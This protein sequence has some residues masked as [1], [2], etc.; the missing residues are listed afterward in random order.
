MP[1]PEGAAELAVHAFHE[2]AADGAPI[3]QRRAPRLLVVSNTKRRDAA[4]EVRA[5]MRPRS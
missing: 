4:A 3:R 1:D 2:R 5:Y